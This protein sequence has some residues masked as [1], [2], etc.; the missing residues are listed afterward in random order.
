MIHKERVIT[1]LNKKKPDRVPIFELLID[2]ISVARLAKLLFSETGVEVKKTRFGE[3][4]TKILDLYCSVIE[5]MDIDSTTTNFS[6]GL[7]EIDESH[8]KD[9]FG[10]LYYLSEHGEPIPLEGPAKNLE[11]AKKIDMVSKLKDEDFDGVRY[12]IEKVGKGK[13]HFLNV[14]DPYKL[15]WRLTGGMQNLLM[16]Y[17]SDPE[18]VTALARTAADFDIAVIEKASKIGIDIIAVPGDLATEENTI[19]SPSHYREFIKPYHKELV[20]HAHKNGL[21][22]VK[23][24]DGNFWPLMDDFIEVG[25]DGIHPIQPQCMD[26][27]EVKEYTAGKVCIL[28]NIDCRNLLPF[29]S[30]EEVKQKV[31]ETIRIA[32]KDGGYIISSSNSI[33]PGVKPENYIAMINATH[34]YGVY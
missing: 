4:S 17:I 31:K 22:I 24:T 3:E 13:A 25:F 16:H 21:K 19:M 34:E 12:V 8:G 18:M 9:K 11:D 5:E 1:A 28:G 23:H 6:V 27:G 15:S 26:I 32:G 2:E 10:T 14:L 20:N 29:G 30:E 33:H 7:K